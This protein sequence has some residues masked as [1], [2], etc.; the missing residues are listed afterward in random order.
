L[1]AIARN[2]EDL[3]VPKKKQRKQ[4]EPF[5]RIRK[6]PS[7]RFQAGYVGPD[8][9]LHNGISTFEM[10]LDARAWLTTERR[11]IEAGTWTARRARNNPA[12]KPATL[13]AFA[14]AWLADRELKPRTRVLYRSLLDRESCLSWATCR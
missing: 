13:R 3:G 10:L 6:L 8:L 11:Y 2:K 12:T 14:E 9:A 1:H 7:G 4:R 5:G